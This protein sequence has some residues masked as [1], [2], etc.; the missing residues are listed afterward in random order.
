MRFSLAVPAALVLFAAGAAGATTPA[1]TS[2]TPPSAAPVV[3]CPQVIMPPACRPGGSGVHLPTGGV[4]GQGHGRRT[5]T[6]SGGGSHTSSWGRG[7]RVVVASRGGSRGY[8]SYGVSRSSRATYASRSEGRSGRTAYRERTMYVDRSA[9]RERDDYARNDRYDD[10]DSDRGERGVRYAGPGSGP[11]YRDTWSG[12]GGR[13]GARPGRVPPRATSGY[14]YS[15][16]T[17]DSDRITESRRVEGYGDRDGVSGYSYSYRSPP[18]TY[19][20]ERYGYAGGGHGPRVPGPGADR[21]SDRFDHRR[22]HDEDMDRRDRDV[23]DRDD[24]GAERDSDRG[25]GGHHD[26]FADNDRDGRDGDHRRGHDRDGDDRDGSDRDGGQ[27]GHRGHGDGYTGGG[28][29]YGYQ[30]HGAGGSSYSSSSSSY[31]S[32]S[33][34]YGSGAAY[35]SGVYGGGVYGQSGYVVGGAGRGCNCGPGL[36]GN[37]TYPTSTDEDGFLTWANREDGGN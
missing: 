25:R 12:Y 31:G 27:D 19:T 11:G 14:G 36:H 13:Y 17:E 5:R 30:H 33:S 15:Y 10:R 7:S 37:V 34:S 18:R 21:Y 26:R 23:D 35:G 6:S 24:A 20:Y 2:A 29:V 3:Y 9:S 28:T 4:P 32:S 16:S 1:G 8:D 22:G